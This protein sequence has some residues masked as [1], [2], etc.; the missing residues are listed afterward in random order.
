V[1][2]IA[3]PLP[4]PDG[5]PREPDWAW[6][7]HEYRNGGRSLREIATDAG[8]SH[9]AISK[10]AKHDGWARQLVATP[11]ATGTGNHLGNQGDGRLL[12][13]APS[14]DDFDD[15]EFWEYAEETIVAENQEPVSVYVDDTGAIAFRQ[16]LA[17]ES[18]DRIVRIRPEF[19]PRLLKRLQSLMHRRAANAPE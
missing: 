8:V 16:R 18:E 2:E 19:V 13:C 11:V 4:E 12:A 1:S 17:Q 10:R 3:L 14:L 15:D 9:Q 6:I 7:E 5:K